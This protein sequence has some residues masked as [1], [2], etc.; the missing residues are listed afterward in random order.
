M[1]YT[2]PRRRRRL[3]IA[4]VIILILIVLAILAFI[5]LQFQKALT[6]KGFVE[7]KVNK[8][9]SSPDNT[10]VELKG[11]CSLLSI[12]ITQDQGMAIEEGIRGVTGPRPSTHDIIVSI[13]E[14]FGIQP[15][16]IKITRMEEGTY[17]AELYLSS[18]NHLLILDIR[19]SDAIAISVRTKTP[20]YVNEGLV[21]KTC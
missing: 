14:G 8:I 4:S 18:W 7:M 15:T 16:I 3:I 19:P 1:W 6:T 9:T 17:F 11:E 5:N 13:L 2:R 21:T 12:Y 20:I 10:I